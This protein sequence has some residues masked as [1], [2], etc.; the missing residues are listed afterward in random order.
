MNR[1]L[2]EMERKNEHCFITRYQ[3]KMT[4]H[5]NNKKKY[6]TQL[7]V[8]KL[9]SLKQTGVQAESI[10]LAKSSIFGLRPLI[11]SDLCIALISP[12]IS[13]NPLFSAP[14]SDSRTIYSHFVVQDLWI[15]A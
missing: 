13:S 6:I 4:N 5:R 7:G 3:I 12:S 11:L 15:K 14:R 8:I 9:Q 10:V 2:E 1:K